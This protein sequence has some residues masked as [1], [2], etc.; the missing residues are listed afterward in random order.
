[1]KG[2]ELLSIIPARGG[3]KRLKRKNLL[4]INGIPLFLRA[5]RLAPGRVVVS[6]DDEEIAS[7]ARVR[8]LEVHYR[9]PVDDDQTVLEVAKLVAR[10]LDWTGDVLAVQPTV[11]PIRSWELKAL[12]MFGRDLQTS[13]IATQY[14][15]H[16]HWV[17]PDG[18]V[19]GIDYELG[20]YFWPAGQVGHSP[21][22]YFT[23]DDADFIDID[24]PS[25]LQQAR[26]SPAHIRF[27]AAQPTTWN[28][29]GHMRRAQTLSNALQHHN[30]DFEAHHPNQKWD[31]YIR[32]KGDSDVS[33]IL[34]H[35]IR[36]A[37]VVTFEDRGPGAQ[38]ADLI[39]NAHVPP[40][41]LPQER[42][43]PEWAVIR[44]EF[45]SLP[46]YEVRR[47]A[48]NILALFGGTDAR[49]LADWVTTRV[50]AATHSGPGVAEAMYEAD[51]LISGAGQVVHEAALVGVPTVVIS[52]TM[53]EATHTHL[54]HDSG[55]IFLGQASDVSTMQFLWVVSSLQDDYML[56]YEMSERAKKHVDGKGVDR[57]VHAIE[58][59][60]M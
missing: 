56:R 11:H 55:N 38:Y 43:G 47:D 46:K 18:R 2:I 50:P 37:K 14:I 60:L 34:P 54:G 25:D 27:D 31:I 51:I 40:L 4:P 13:V 8:D 28:G 23:L 52:A 36:G 30:I 6:T 29:S 24:H 32:D 22:A 57:I 17:E 35:K 44:P 41:G 59:L 10:E 39:I 12:V 19:F 21:N 20:I 15:P 58:G 7:M 5:A 49:N 26:L 16:R 53:R 9:E 42:T 3:S 1:M 45:L 33:D 48:D